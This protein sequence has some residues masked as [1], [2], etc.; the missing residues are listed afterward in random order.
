MASPYAEWLRAQ[1]LSEGEKPTKYF[2]SLEKSNYIGKTIKH[3]QLD[4]GKIITD[5]KDILLEVRNFY[6]TLFLARNETK[7]IDL[8]LIL[9]DNVKKLIDTESSLLEGELELQ[10]VNCALKT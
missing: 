3:I 1:W 6:D 9:D 8:E 4:S 5:Q 2:C 10:E 7:N